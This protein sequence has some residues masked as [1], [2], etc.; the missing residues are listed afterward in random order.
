MIDR[1]LLDR[2]NVELMEAVGEPDRW[3]HLLERFETAFGACG[4][5]LVPAEP[6]P[7]FWWG[8][9]MEE[10]F[11][12]YVAE[13]WHLEGRDPYRRAMSR[14]RRGL[15]STDDDIFAPGELART[16]YFNEF[17]RPRDV[18]RWLGAPV[19]IEG[20]LHSI[21]LH[22]SHR[23]EEFDR[24]EMAAV[25]HFAGRLGEVATLCAGIAR[26]HL[27]GVT[28]A[29]HLVGQPALAL[30][31]TGRVLV[32]NA[33]AEA[34]MGPDFRV[35]GGDLRLGDR[36][37]AA[38]LESII[39][40]AGWSPEGSVLAAS[41][42]LARRAGAPA[43]LLRAL[44]VD[45]AARCRFLGAR[46]LLLVREV[47]PARPPGEDVLRAAFGL[48]AAEARLAARLARGE[49]MEAAAEALAISRE[50]ARSQAKAVYAKTGVSRQAGLVA[51]V[52]SLS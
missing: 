34:L 8:P 37:A 5:G 2:I 32:M 24:V 48:T 25:G 21:S 26:R 35:S 3:P 27:A 30:H 4:V 14:H 51:L 46:L 15:V 49:T 1:P 45:G 38:R 31:A 41:P 23:Q 39:S 11:A 13:G 36:A 44:P 47:A 52:L 42:V 18:G 17:A 7:D 43:L 12:A 33:G 40:K 6:S 22:K 29:L 9:S 50:T 28:D 16:P 19:L 10:S 20:A